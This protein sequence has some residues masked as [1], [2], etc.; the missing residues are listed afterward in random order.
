MP[1]LPPGHGIIYEIR[2]R[3]PEPGV[4]PYVYVGQTRKPRGVFGRYGRG[5]RKVERG[6]RRLYNAVEKHGRQNFFAQITRV[7]PVELL[8]ENEVQA[9]A[10]S[11]ARGDR[12][13]NVRPGGESGELSEET[14]ALMG[15]A[16][17]IAQNRPEVRERNSLSRKLFWSR[18]GARER[19]SAAAK[20]SQNRPEV[21]KQKSAAMKAIMARPEVRKQ[22][23]AAMRARAPRFF[24]GVPGHGTVGPLG[25]SEL[26]EQ[27]P[28]MK[29]S[30]GT[31]GIV[32]RGERP[33][34]K[35]VWLVR[36]A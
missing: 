10:A 13:L 18:P 34:H 28:G 22:R 14:K 23:S 20:I 7:L 3:S 26:V 32:S 35:G 33:H 15:A 36:K 17:K 27:F 24:W 11:K 19:N 9:I 30:K 12:N 31:L 4:P 5:L 25:Q 6:Q 8:N 1:P 29:L 2:E 16:Q 21:R